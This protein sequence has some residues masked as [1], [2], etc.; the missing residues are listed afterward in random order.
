METIVGTPTRK[1][2]LGPTK[3]K[4]GARTQPVHSR[5]AGMG[6]GGVTQYAQRQAMLAT[7]HAEAKAHTD[8]PIFVRKEAVEAKFSE[9]S[10]GLMDWQIY[11]AA[12][13]PGPGHYGA[14]KPL[15]LPNGG[16]F[17]RF[18]PKGYADDM[19]KRAMEGPGP[20][21]Y[22]APPLPPTSGGRF[23]E[24]RPK[25]ELEWIEY[26]ASHLPGPADIPAPALPKPSGGRFSTAKPK[27]DVDWLMYRAAQMP[28][29]SDYDVKPPL[30]P[31]GGTFNKGRSKTDLDW[32]ELRAGQ[33]PG[34]GQ[35]GIGVSRGP[36]KLSGGKF[37]ESKPKS[38]LDW[39]IYRSSQMPGPGE[40]DA[41]KSLDAMFRSPSCRLLGRTGP[42]HMPFPYGGPKPAPFRAHTSHS[43]SSASHTRSLDSTRRSVSPH[44]KGVRTSRCPCSCPVALIEGRKGAHAQLTHPCAR[45][46]LIHPCARPWQVDFELPHS[47]ESS[48]NRTRGSG[49]S[50]ARSR[51][52]NGVC[53][54]VT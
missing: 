29:P 2:R 4:E 13:L 40:Y 25:S 33:L 42:V 48:L 8:R 46:A 37:N 27:S 12:Q 3:G 36:L 35:Y 23:N 17:S 47:G 51:G 34:P 24:S 49:T 9:A 15:P 32:I 20:T 38:E 16:R 5:R 22:P 14:G 7:K 18:K 26:N 28:G 30:P 50:R 41:Q 21:D 54:V 1:A 52:S 10:A 19:I 39:I 53:V 6:R 43:T 45:I 11:R 31:R 44:T